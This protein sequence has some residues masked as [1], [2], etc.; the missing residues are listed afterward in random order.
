MNLSTRITEDLKSAMKSGDKLRLE[1]IRMVRAQ[2]LEFEKSGANRE[3]TEDDGMKI[4]LSAVKKRKEAV[5]VYEQAGRQ[6]LADKEKKEIEIIQEYLPKQMSQ[7]EAESIVAKVITEVG[8]TSA[9]DFGKVMPAVMKQLKG[10]IDGRIINDIV[11][12]KL[13]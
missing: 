13:S 4:L 10:K 6:E 2:I 9:K 1:T 3:M 8:A 7:E 11:K 12:Q 5:E